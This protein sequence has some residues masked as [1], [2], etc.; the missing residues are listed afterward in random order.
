[1][2]SR[3]MSDRTRNE[4]IRTVH[5]FSVWLGDSALEASVSDVD[6]WLASKPSQVTRWSYFT[7][8]RSFFHWVHQVGLSET[9]LLGNL[10]APRRPRYS[11]RPVANVHIQRVLEGPLRIS[12]RLY[13]LLATY[14]GLRVH[15]IAKINGRDYDRITGELTVLGKGNQLAIIP[16]MDDLRPILAGM[17]ASGWWFP[18]PT[19]GHV[20]SRAV[21]SA[22]KRAFARYGIDMSAHQLRHSFGTNLLAADANLRVVQTLMRH[23]SIQSTALYVKVT[24]DQQRQALDR[25]QLFTDISANDL[26]REG[27]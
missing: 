26:G 10:P 6:E 2:K 23:Q 16:V 1:M 4:P 18:S 24:H 17:P 21:G 20:S 15:E 5:A 22:I 7:S 3:S 12:T 13:I 25:L 27:Q 11:P 19:G 14:V 8:L 9:D